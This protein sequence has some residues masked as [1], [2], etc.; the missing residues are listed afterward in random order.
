MSTDKAFWVEF[1]PINPATGTTVRVRMT[2]LNTPEATGIDLVNGEWMPYMTSFPDIE[3]SVFDGAFDGVS[4]AT[5]SG[6]EASDTNGFGLM[7]PSYIWDGA[8]VTVYKGTES[9]TTLGALTKIFTGSVTETPSNEEGEIKW[10]IRDKSY[11]FDVEA[12]KITYAGTSG[13]DGTV[14]MTGVSKPFAIGEVLNI[15]PFLVDPSY[16]IYQ[17]HG[18]GRTIGVQ[19]LYENGLGFG[20]GQTTVAWAGSIAAT[21]NALKAVTLAAGQWVDAPSIGMFRLGGEPLQGGVI[22]CDVKGQEKSAGVLCERIDDVLALLVSQDASLSA[23]VDGTTYSTLYAGSN[24]QT[25]GDYFTGPIN[26]GET[27]A[28]YLAQC[29]AYYFV[30]SAGL[31]R[32]GFVRMGTPALEIRSDGTTYPIPEGVKS[33]PVSAPYK[34]M[35]MGADKVFRVHSLDEIS[36]ALY[37]AFLSVDAKVPTNAD[38]IPPTSLPEGTIW[39]ASDNHPY[40]FGS[41]PWKGADATSW[42]GA[43]TEPWS[44]GGYADAQDQIGVAA[45]SAAAAAQQLALDAQATA[46]GKVQSF[47]QSSPPIAEGVGD[48]WFDTANGYKQYRWSGFSWDAVQDASIGLALTAAAGA[49]ATADG[50]VT[51][52]VDEVAPI[53]EGLGD[54]WFKQS[55]GELRRWNGSAWGD[56]LVDLTAAAIPRHEPTSAALSFTADSGGAVSPSSQLPETLL[57]SRFLGTTNV[58]E[59]A[60]TVWTVDYTEGL[61]GG[62]PT[63]SDGVLTLPSGLAISPSG[64]LVRVKSSRNGFDIFTDVTVTKINAP[65]S[66]GG[67]GGGTSVNDSSFSDVPSTTSI[68]ISDTMTVKTGSAGE[69]NFAGILSVSC[70][71]ELPTGSFGAQAQ[72]KYKLT[73][74]GSLTNAGA[75]IDD[76]TPCVIDELFDPYRVT[77]SAGQINV[78]RSLTGLTAMT[79]YDVELWMKAD[80][81]GHTLSFSGTATV[82]GS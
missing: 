52:F 42:T 20:A 53:P 32:F 14:E 63:V 25:V 23:L 43:D 6:V 4:E 44:G 61:T 2:T 1:F 46:D 39:F 40:R 41:L 16:L 26:I 28:K 78:A 76:T 48:I 15:E 68:K 49:Q 3:I 69:L 65:P 58:S 35:R 10:S 57:I 72:W 33:E 56:P 7:F 70:P 77:R 60:G 64:A 51:T 62:T 67:S 55:T 24:N 59:D 45:V 11:L 5:V 18:Y 38:L 12:M 17:Y 73:S 8:S 66:S 80:V 82:T 31:L 37:Q 13:Y 81:S 9:T 27:M 34:R 75:A 21:Y 36:D 71:K 47:Y 22:T 79:N 50:K 74:G 30:S 29:G 19:G 54:M